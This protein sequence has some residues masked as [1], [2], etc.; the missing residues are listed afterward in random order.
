MDQMFD[1]AQTVPQ[2]EQSKRGQSDGNGDEKSGQ[3]QPADGGHEGDEENA[4]V[5]SRGMGPWGGGDPR[6]QAERHPNHL[7]Y[8]LHSGE[9][10]RYKWVYIAC[11]PV[12]LFVGYFYK[13]LDTV[14]GKIQASILHIFNSDKP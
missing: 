6:K 8:Y 7:N 4:V 13:Y 1:V 11:P 2:W 5:A 9:M 14:A 3:A 10:M 12:W